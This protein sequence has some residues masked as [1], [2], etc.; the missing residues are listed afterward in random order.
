M[1]QLMCPHG[2]FV[3]IT[4]NCNQQYGLYFYI[5]FYLKQPVKQATFH[6]TLK[7]NG[8]LFEHNY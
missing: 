5:V 3:K 7:K 6:S 2:G 4:L 1:L 8:D